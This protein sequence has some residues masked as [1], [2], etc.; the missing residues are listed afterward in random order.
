MDRRVGCARLRERH[1]GLGIDPD[2]AQTGEIDHPP[3][4][5]RNRRPG[6]G[7]AASAHRDGD[8]EPV[9]EREDLADVGDLAGLDHRVG[10]E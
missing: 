2:A 3:A 4:A 8:A 5:Q 10:Q 7:C 9:G 6:E 1:A